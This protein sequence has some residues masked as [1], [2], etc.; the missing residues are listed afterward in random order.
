MKRRGHGELFRGVGVHERIGDE[1][2]LGSNGNASRSCTTIS[3]S[4][5]KGKVEGVGTRIVSPN[6]LRRGRSGTRIRV[7]HKQPCSSS[8]GARGLDPYPPFLFHVEHPPREGSL[9]ARRCSTWNKSG[10]P[11]GLGIPAAER[12]AI[13][14]RRRAAG[15]SARRSRGRS[16]R[17]PTLCRARA[18]FRLSRDWRGSSRT[19][20]SR[21]CTFQ[22]RA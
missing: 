10:D 8:R 5:G 4:A 14:W 18:A 20:K 2:P 9:G 6:D 19:G 7:G 22:G 3:T 21:G 12:A 11:L 15:G 1:P 16:C 17:A 13:S